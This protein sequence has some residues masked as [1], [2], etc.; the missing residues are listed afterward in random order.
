[1]KKL[2]YLLIL[3]SFFAFMISC[4][5]NEQTKESD[6]EVIKEETNNE[7]S[8]DIVKVEKASL[9]Y[10]HFTKRCA[11]CNAIKS[12]SEEVAKTYADKADY[13]EYNLDEV[14]GEEMGKKMN[15]DGQTYYLV[16]GDSKIDLTEEA[17]LNAKSN[18]DKFKA[19][20]KEKLDAVL[21]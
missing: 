8:T 1:M 9:V 16:F 20:L 4:S 18:P 11:T 3:I 14:E 17:F 15:A 2:N 12:V 13:I 7:T 5:N 19:I 10:F 6:S 21:L